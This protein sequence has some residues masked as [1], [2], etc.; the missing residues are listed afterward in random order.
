MI[1]IAVTYGFII[2]MS[3]DWL[4]PQPL[5]GYIQDPLTETAHDVAVFIQ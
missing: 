4:H 5:H 2:S 1:N 3:E